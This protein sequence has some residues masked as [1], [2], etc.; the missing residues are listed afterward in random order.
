M[1]ARIR[2]ASKAAL[3]HLTISV[4]MVGAVSSILFYVWFRSPYFDL[5]DGVRLALIAIVVDVVCGPMTTAIV[6]NPAKSKRELAL[7]LSLVVLI[8]LAALAYAVHV[9]A[10]SRPVALVFEVDRFVA[11]AAGQVDERELHSA[12][13]GSRSLP[14]LVAPKLLGTRDPKDSVEMLKSVERSLAGEEPS[15]RPSW[16]QPYTQSIPKVKQQM[17]SLA[18]L[19][20]RLSKDEGEVLKRAIAAA[21]DSNIPE[22]YLPLTSQKKLNNWVVLLSADAMPVG[23]AAVPGWAD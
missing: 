5:F 14:L 17:K 6:F 4:V 19:T 10:Q 12:P 9:A 7:D 1:K 22:Y 23:F 13:E 3:I 16:W 11:V 18:D 15:V 8:Q 21:P 2:A 20:Q